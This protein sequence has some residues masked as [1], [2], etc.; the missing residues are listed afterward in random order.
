[1]PG[2]FAGE[3]LAGVDEAYRYYF[4]IL[5]RAGTI[6][7]NIV[8]G[9]AFF[10][11]ARRMASSKIKDFL[12]ITGIGDIIVGIALSTS[13]L[14]PTYGVA[15]HSLV[16]LSSYLFSVGLYVCAI[17]LSQ[18]SSLR[19]SIR[20]SNIK[21][22]ENIGSAQMEQEVRKRILKMVEDG[23]D[24]MEEQTG[25]LSYS[26]TEKDVREYMELVIH[27]RKQSTVLNKKEPNE[28]AN[29]DNSGKSTGS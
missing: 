26:V 20:R 29:E 5:F 15:A 17:S 9:L 10:V 21:L 14:E 3:S 24:L 7:G 25:G 2:F 6:A 27:E 12:I 1:M 22:V 13:A 8:F 11:I 16:L 28:E 23:K 19:K 4:R 18:D